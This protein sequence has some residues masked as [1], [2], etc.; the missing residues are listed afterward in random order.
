MLWGLGCLLHRKRI[1][2]LDFRQAQVVQVFIRR[3]V[4]ACVPRLI[5]A[6]TFRDNN[7]HALPRPSQQ[8]SVR[9]LQIFL[10]LSLANVLPPIPHE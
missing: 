7:D 9:I 4:K 10:A 2:P 5:A 3:V 1:L 6:V 8:H